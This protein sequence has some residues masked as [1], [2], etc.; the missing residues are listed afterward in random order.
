MASATEKKKRSGIAT[1]A[2]HRVDLAQ[3]MILNGA[4]P[5]KER[6]YYGSRL[7]SNISCRTKE[8][9]YQNVELFQPVIYD[10][11]QQA[12][13]FDPRWIQYDSD[14][15]KSR[16]IVNILFPTPYKAWWYEQRRR[17]IEGYT[18]GGVHLTGVY[19][20]FLNFWRIRAK[21]KGVGWIAPRF[22]DLQ[23]EIADGIA[24][25]Q[26]EDSNFLWLKRRQIGASEFLACYAGHEYTFYPL[27]RGLIVGGE[28]KYALNTID[29][30]SAGLDG[31]LPNGANAGREFFKRRKAGLDKREIFECGFLDST[32]A[33]L[34]YLSQV[35]AI[36][37][38][39]N[40]QSAN[41]KAPTFCLL[42][43]AGINRHLEVV[44]EM[45]L[46]AMQERG[47][48]NGRIVVIVGTGGDMTRGATQLMNM[49]YKPGEYNILPSE[50]L[51]EEGITGTGFFSPAWKFHIMD[52]DGNSY[53]EPSIEDIEAE[54]KNKPKAGL[55]A[56]KTQMPLTPSEAFI[57]GGKCPFNAEK[58]E[59]QQRILRQANAKEL[60]QWG[61]VDWIFDEKEIEAFD[62]TKKK[63][64]RIP[65]GVEWIP[66]PEGQRGELDESGDL[67]YPICLTEHPER[68]EKNKATFRV[69]FTEQNYTGLYAAGMDPYNKDEAESAYSQ[70]SFA[71]AKGYLNVNC[72]S[73]CFPARLTYRPHDKNKFY[74]M[75][76]RLQCYFGKCRVLIEW[77]N[78]APLDWYKQNGW[79]YLLKERPQSTYADVINSQAVNK[80]GIDPSTKRVWEE[81]YATYIEEYCQ[82]MMD[83]E[84]VGRALA[85]RKTKGYNCDETISY[86]LAWEHIKDDIHCGVVARETQKENTSK[87]L[88]GTIKTGSGFQSYWGTN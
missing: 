81:H 65:I 5:L 53:M 25:A 86:M 85:Y 75:C 9:L 24:Q 37:T 71:I 13:K 72:T 6:F 28:D 16:R 73:H 69:L 32:G 60:V 38:A 17:C 43:E 64:K 77:S 41:G 66:C 20:F 30:V 31:F 33:K 11:E 27:S 78:D 3:N 46:P 68:K 22:I 14:T 18:I 58:L 80:Y 35:E 84:Q 51:Y 54:R 61:R 57:I 87:P 15:A 1:I 74:E 42:E 39:D 40:V 79:E 21:E 62:M 4:K 70:G 7:P 2:G 45:I 48:L 12:P 50:E 44:Y 59:A 82:N 29:K 63:Q 23:K 19:Y 36:T 56:Y 26:K 49:F 10:M 88:F 55:I 47:R 76:V 8:G 34:G 67:M 52:E 83:P